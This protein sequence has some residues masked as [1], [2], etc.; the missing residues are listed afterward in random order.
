M[1]KIFYSLLLIP[2]LTACSFLE[3][4]PPALYTEEQIYSSDEGAWGAL[5]A[6]YGNL[7]VYENYGYRHHQ[8][9]NSSSV[10]YT[11]VK[12]SS[13]DGRELASLN[14][15]TTNKVVEAVF[16]NSYATINMLNS[17]IDAIERSENVS[18]DVK[19]RVRGD[20]HF[21]RAYIYFDI[22]RL[23]G[24]APLITKPGEGP[25]P[26][27]E[28]I[29][30][31]DRILQD[32]EIAISNLTE[33]K[34]QA[35][36]M[37]AGHPCI[38]S[39]YALRAKVYVAMACIAENPDE[40]FDATG[41]GPSRQ[42]WENAYNDAFFVYEHGNYTLEP[43]VADVFDIDNRYSDESMFELTLTKA[44]GNNQFWSLYLPQQNSNGSPMYYGRSYTDPET[45][46]TKMKVATN[47]FACVVNKEVL[48]EHMNTYP[49][50]PRIDA[51]Y[52]YE[53]WYSNSESGTPGVL[54]DLYPSSAV[55]KQNKTSCWAHCKK[56]IDPTTDNATSSKNQPLLRYA[57]VLLTLA[58]AA[59]EIDKPKSEVF[60]YVRPV[61][62]RARQSAQ[63]AVNPMDW[64][65]IPEIAG[66]DKDGI[67][68]AIMR[69]RIFEL[70]GEFHDWFDIRRR[71]F[72]YY[73]S[74]ITRHNDRVRLSE[75]TW[76]SETNAPY[77]AMD[78]IFDEGDL[79]IKRSM[80]L[81]IP[82]KEIN[83]NENISDN[84]Y[85]YSFIE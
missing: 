50:D 58:E 79:F 43:N 60:S 11:C 76:N 13:T 71:G 15:T 65:N 73:K 68:N 33:D 2:F 32:L 55:A 61:L 39:A 48:D 83:E 63:D 47:S 56:Y 29:D 27:A 77:N 57:D 44:R 80:L 35:D 40:P 52:I 12:N 54:M 19:T 64:E 72:D 28:I 75:D 6:C 38:Y 34:G 53:G 31:Y 37:T 10:L 59:N 1:K 78:I 26:R 16:S 18:P 51:T 46:D 36:P 30:I 81:P 84:N 25:N 24:K 7:S 22:V 42:Y 8:L 45:K 62:T 17:V 3:E 14:I 66:A 85:G 69:E 23:W 82:Q 41:F 49:G 21:L 20:A 9:L 70:H 5:L 67:R 74:Y 4:N